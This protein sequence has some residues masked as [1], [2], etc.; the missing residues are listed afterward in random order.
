MAKAASNTPTTSKKTT[1][2]VTFNRVYPDGATY[3]VTH[4][5]NGAKGP[6]KARALV[7]ASRKAIS[8]IGGSL[9]NVQIS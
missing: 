5:F 7:E 4:S 3:A 6:E 8:A 1:A 2:T 9:T